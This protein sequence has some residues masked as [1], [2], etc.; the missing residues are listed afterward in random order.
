[1]GKL[2]MTNNVHLLYSHAEDRQQVL[3]HN[4]LIE[5]LTLNLNMLY[6]FINKLKGGCYYMLIL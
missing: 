1:M 3:T 2:E 5:N 4:F 6:Y